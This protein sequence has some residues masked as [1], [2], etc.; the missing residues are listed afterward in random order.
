MGNPL[1][2]LQWSI[3][4]INAMM[5]SDDEPFYDIVDTYV[6]EI[7]PCANQTCAAFLS[8]SG[9]PGSIHYCGDLQSFD[10]HAANLPLHIPAGAAYR[11][12]VLSG[13]PC[14]SISRGCVRN[15]NRR[16]FGLHADPSRIWWLAYQGINRLQQDHHQWMFLMVEN[17]VPASVTDLQELDSTA[18]FR[19][20]MNVPPEFGA[21]RRRF[22]W[23]SVHFNPGSLP[24]PNRPFETP[25]K[26]FSL[27]QG[28][29]YPHSSGLPCVRAIFPFLFWKYATEDTSLS[30]QDRMVVE[31]CLLWHE[32]TAS[33]RLPTISIWGSVMGLHPN[34]IAILLITHPCIG[35]L[36]AHTSTSTKRAPCGQW[37]YCDNCSSILTMMG[38]SWHLE[39]SSHYVYQAMKEFLSQSLEPE[40]FY[41]MFQYT[42]PVHRCD[43][44]CVMQRT[45]M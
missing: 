29:K 12:L 5:V 44:L 28:W 2:A 10:S 11:I 23:T 26:L 3:E 25:A 31:Q 8:Y 35:N 24:T 6:F 7:D 42:V 38:E 33:L 27:P 36:V 1:L 41:H 18:G 43:N 17:V 39:V 30:Q 16:F 45:N 40:S 13:T 22:I 37:A 20:E 15:P 9:Y 34:L 32:Q 19:M 4:S 14:K 21:P